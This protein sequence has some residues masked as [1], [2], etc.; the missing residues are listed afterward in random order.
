[1]AAH[2]K[3]FPL[4]EEHRNLVL[5]ATLAIAGTRAR[6][7]FAS[8]APAVTLSQA[9]AAGESG[10]ALLAPTLLIRAAF[11]GMGGDMAMLRNAASAWHRRSCADGALWQE[12]LRQAFPPA[13]DEDLISAKQR[14]TAEDIPL[15]A[16]DF[17]CSNVLD[18][19]LANQSVRDAAMT[20]AGVDT[21]AIRD[22]CS[23]AM[24]QHSSG[25]S[26]KSDWDEGRALPSASSWDG[27]LVPEAPAVGRS[28]RLWDV[29]RRPC[30]QYASDLVARQ[31]FFV[32]TVAASRSTAADATDAGGAPVAP[33][34]AKAHPRL[35]GQFTVEDF[36]TADQERELLLW[37]DAEAPVS[38]GG[39]GVWEL[40]NFNGPAYGKRWGARTDLRKRVVTAGEPLPAPLADLAARFRDVDQLAAWPGPNEANALDYRKEE[41]HFIS[42]PCDDRFLSGDVLVNL[43]LAGDALMSFTHDKD[44]AR[45]TERVLLRRR[46]LQIQVRDVRYNWQHAIHNS[47]L[48]GP[49]RVSITFRRAK[50]PVAEG[51][52]S[53]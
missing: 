3:G 40:R 2:L 34:L 47:D 19:V 33:I 7:S 5:R 42:A 11:G 30:R 17:H 22:A 32:P 6:E 16:I 14:L 27:S 21:H 35:R 4:E 25:L 36:I 20:A 48:G 44:P 9:C 41:G 31:L 38:A 15:S 53:S 43:S 23:S 1:M 8:S 50:V 52:L 51:G 37:L 18:I 46:S 39:S 26:A 10:A 12:R 45:A 29:I 28:L 24:W 13:T 49:R